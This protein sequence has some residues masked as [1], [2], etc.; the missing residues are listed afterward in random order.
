MTRRIVVLG[1]TGSIGRQAL[2]VIAARDDMR[3]VGLAAGS[4][5]AQ[6]DAQARA[7]GAHFACLGA[8]AAV[9]LARLPKADVV[10]NAIVGAAGLRASTAALEAGKVLALANKESLVAGGEVCRAAAA[11]GGGTIV[12]VDSEH[13]AIAQCL[14]GRAGADV[15]RIVLTASG[16]P[17][18]TRGDLSAVTPAEALA[19]PTWTM[20]PKITVDSATLMNKGLEVIEA[21]HLFGFGYDDIDV[22]VH[23]QSVVH[24][25]V[26]LADGSVVLQAAP[27]DMRIP[28]QAALTYPQRGTLSFERIDFD[29]LGVL[30]FEP[31]DRE[32]FPALSLAYDAGRRGGTHPAVLNAAN[33]V[34]VG[35]FLSGEL[36]F[37]G[38]AD[39]VAGVLSEHDGAAGDDLG[40]VLAADAWARRR[41]RSLVDARAGER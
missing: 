27:A 32:R 2:D 29:K 10:L 41:A 38:I 21:H 24:G 13:A 6:L 12:P 33:E 11:R 7:T 9:E 25:A 30:E 20:G 3:V 19:H 37:T 1:S 15:A 39:V 17:F 28:I 26:E 34:A 36:P 23:P 40:A 8:E 31:V 22:V 35:A 18:R 14:E 4:D 16:G 5:R